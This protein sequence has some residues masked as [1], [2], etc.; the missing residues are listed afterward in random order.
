M[1]KHVN[2]KM[3]CYTATTTTTF[4]T[5][6]FLH[7]VVDS[8]Q[9]AT[10]LL[11]LRWQR[12][13]WEILRGKTRTRQRYERLT[14]GHTDFQ[15]RFSNQGT[16]NKWAWHAC[17]N[18]CLQCG[19]ARRTMSQRGRDSEVAEILQDPES[20]WNIFGSINAGGR[21]SHQPR[22]FL[23]GTK[24]WSTDAKT[25]PAPQHFIIVLLLSTTPP[26]HS[27]ANQYFWWTRCCKTAIYWD[28]L[29]G[30]HNPTIWYYFV[31][32]SLFRVVQNNEEVNDDDDFVVQTKLSQVLLTN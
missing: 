6:C 1:D 5:E 11:L 12:G 15:Y 25:F 10:L 21:C 24:W 17:R 22:R 4:A 14:D 20:I 23:R 13:F 9:W 18:N 30:S 29:S 32:C 19:N 26:S 7:L 27:C 3:A 28:S 31:K 2:L 16:H 8:R